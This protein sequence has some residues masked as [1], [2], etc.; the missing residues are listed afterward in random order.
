[1]QPASASLDRFR[2]SKDILSIIERSIREAAHEIGTVNILIAGRTGVGKSTLINEVF[3]GALP[4]R[5][6]VSR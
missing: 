5:G 4:R 1:M 3:R 2:D 6:R